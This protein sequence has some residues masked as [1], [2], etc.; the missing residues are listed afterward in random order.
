MSAIYVFQTIT[1]SHFIWLAN[2]QNVYKIKKQVNVP[3]KHIYSLYTMY[4]VENIEM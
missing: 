4:N 3:H 2:L 1:Q